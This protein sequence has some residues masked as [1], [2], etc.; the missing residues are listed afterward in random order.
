MTFIGVYFGNETDYLDSLN[1]YVS[2]FDKL[3]LLSNI[4]SLGQILYTL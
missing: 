2:W 3:D 1:V 4:E